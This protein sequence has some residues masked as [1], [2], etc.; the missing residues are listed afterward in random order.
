MDKRFIRER[1]FQPFNTTK[2]NAGMGVGV[3]ESREFVYALGGEINV[4][5]EPGAG[6]AFTIKLPLVKSGGSIVKPDSMVLDVDRKTEVI[7]CPNQVGNC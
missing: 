4:V 7:A 2:G 6:T 1:L 5:S 3:Y